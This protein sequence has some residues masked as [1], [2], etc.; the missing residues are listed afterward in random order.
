MEINLLSLSTSPSD[1]ECKDGDLS[2]MMNV[3][4]E[5][6]AL[7][8]I[9]HPEEVATLVLQDKNGAPYGYAASDVRFYIHKV[10][11]DDVTVDDHTN[12]LAIVAGNSGNHVLWCDDIYASQQVWE[13]IDGL[14]G[15]KVNALSFNGRVV[16]IVGDTSLR[17]LLW[18]GSSYKY[19]SLDSLS[20]DVQIHSYSENK[21][22]YSASFGSTGSNQAAFIDANGNVISNAD[23]DTKVYG[24]SRAGMNMFMEGVDAFVTQA[25]EEDDNLHKYISF[26]FCAVKMYDGTYT[27]FSDIF[28]LAPR[29]RTDSFVFNIEN[30]TLSVNIECA[31]HKH[32]IS[33]AMQGIEEYKNLIQGIDVFVCPP[34][35]YKNFDI[36]E[37]WS[38][39]GYKE[40]SYIKL[41]TVA[42]LSI[43]LRPVDYDKTEFYKQFDNNSF[44]KV[45]SIEKNKIGKTI[46]TAVAEYIPACDETATTLTLEDFHKVDY[47]AKVATNY[48]GRLNIADVTSTI[49]FDPMAQVD[50]IWDK[51]Y[52]PNFST[53]SAPQYLTLNGYKLPFARLS[54]DNVRFTKGTMYCVIRYMDYN[55]THTVYTQTSLGVPLPSIF[56]L[57]CP[58]IE[59]VDIY[60]KWTSASTAQQYWYAENVAFHTSETGNWSYFAFREPANQN[61]GLSFISPV[62]WTGNGTAA[63]TW[64]NM[65]FFTEDTNGAK[66]NAVVSAFEANPHTMSTR[67]RNRIYVSASDNPFVI[68]MTSQVAV[69]NGSVIALAAPTQPISEGQA[70]TT[71]LVA[72]TSE[73]IYP[74]Y[75]DSSTGLYGATQP[76]PRD[77]PI[78]GNDGYNTDAIVSID[79]AIIFPSDRGLMMYAGSSTKCLSD[80]LNGIVNDV[81]LP[82]L[83]EMI[84]NK[85][86][87][88]VVSYTIDDRLKDFL[89]SAHVAYDYTSQRIMAYVPDNNKALVYSLRSGAWGIAENTL[90]QSLNSYPDALA[91]TSGLKVV[92]LYNGSPSSV[93]FYAVT[94]PLGLGAP[95]TLKRISS[96]IIRGLF[97]KSYKDSDGTL[98]KKVTS[99]LYG[100]RDL[101]NW[102]LLN[103][104][105]DHYLRGRFGSPY[106]YFRYA[107]A[108]N[109]E[110]GETIQGISIDATE[111]MNNQIR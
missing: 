108:G 70:G 102:Y 51:S 59:S 35:M 105:V 46:E 33:I 77:V 34:S 21:N 3:I 18:E 10:D 99:A 55:Q 13:K 80:S 16:N 50:Y 45:L 66:Y 63:G 97:A 101:I 84:G 82:H 96:S 106:K 30:T 104:S 78:K 9:P 95:N 109:L 81:T 58:N 92:N 85:G 52:V 22:S 47:G 54:G 25:Q 38:D 27:A 83:G 1:Y 19:C 15:F 31:L 62:Y 103:T 6:G 41:W 69:G 75:V 17:W 98:H 20:Y 43:T 86:T 61:A 37:K 74:L 32:Q 24:I 12:W 90:Q 23:L 40:G 93:L 65:G 5:D 7:H 89:K 48:N 110:D 53:A 29:D 4:N 111:S 42:S 60:I 100:S 88:N 39:L 26:G 71:P 44:H 91:V 72:F 36:R 2:A 68:Q 107:I 28:C 67:Y 57:P 94:R 73:G 56:M 8:P 76:G 49:A 64:D 87:D 79:N 14:D 11:D